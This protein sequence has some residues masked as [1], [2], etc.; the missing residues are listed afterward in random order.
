MNET[1]TAAVHPLE[2][3]GISREVVQAFD[4]MG[5]QNLTAIQQK[6][7]PLMMD[8][9]DIIAI[10]PTGTGKT[11]GFGIPMLEYVNLDDS[12]IQEVVLAPTRELA[13]KRPIPPTSIWTTTPTSRAA[14]SGWLS[15]SPTS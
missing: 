15:R 11:L 14:T 8:G 5:F 3:M 1:Q 10:A 2:E 7:I 9:H 13:P 6:C 12:N 4:W